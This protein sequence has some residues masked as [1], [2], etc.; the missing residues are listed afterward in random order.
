VKLTKFFLQILLL[1]LVMRA[2]LADQNRFSSF[3]NSP[4]PAHYDAIV[5]DLKIQ[6]GK[7][8]EWSS[9]QDNS[10]EWAK[11]I[12]LAETANA[13]AVDLSV[14]LAP[15][16]DGAYLEDLCRAVGMNIRSQ[17]ELI[18]RTLQKN[19]ASEYQQSCMLMLL[20]ESTIDKD[21]AKIA[22][23][24][25]RATAISAVKNPELSDYKEISLMMLYDKIY[26]LRG[27]K[28]FLKRRW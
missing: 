11:F 21:D 19:Q 24:E 14:K 27:E 12:R 25:A 8:K 16:T 3:V 20:P 28:P 17:P 10:N 7:Y 2:S 18:L 15:K 22:E 26:T 1:L 23:L 5:T 13:L 9:F 4:T 6:T